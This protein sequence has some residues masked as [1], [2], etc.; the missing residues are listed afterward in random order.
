MQVLFQSTLDFPCQ[1]R[2]INQQMTA[3]GHPF[4][5]LEFRV[6]FSTKGYIHDSFV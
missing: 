1:T 4:P 5:G 6:N 3:A 2:I